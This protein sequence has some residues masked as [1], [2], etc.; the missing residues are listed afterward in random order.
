MCGGVRWCAVVYHDVLWCTGVY[1]GVWQFAAMRTASSNIRATSE[2]HQRN[3]YIR[4]ASEQHTSAPLCSSVYDPPPTH[5]TPPTPPPPPSHPPRTHPPTTYP[6]SYPPTHRTTH[7][8]THTLT[9]APPITHHPVVLRPGTSPRN[10]GC[11]DL[12]CGVKGVLISGVG[13]R[14]Y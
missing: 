3:I 7:T 10:T 6:R 9:P 8:L 11:T 5:P 4:A 12:G 2:Q 13:F 1:R 14:V